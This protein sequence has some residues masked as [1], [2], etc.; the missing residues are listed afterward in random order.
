MGSPPPVCAC[1]RA[2]ACSSGDLQGYRCVRRYVHVKTALHLARETTVHTEH[3][4]ALGN[5]CAARRA[6]FLLCRRRCRPQA[7][8][9]RGPGRRAAKPQP[10][11]G[12]RP[13]EQVPPRRRSLAR[14]C[15]P[16]GCA[17]HGCR[18]MAMH[19]T[20]PAPDTSCRQRFS[21]AAC[22]RAESPGPRTL[23]ASATSSG[24]EGVGYTA[25]GLGYR[26]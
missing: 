13:R 2:C 9:T 25:G 14:R 19:C 26:G 5:S 10:E 11:P 21:P 17:L 15:T 22:P 1:V 18:Y 6:S 24:V 20:V 12:K 7:T 16:H 4:P 8:A 3:T 23:P